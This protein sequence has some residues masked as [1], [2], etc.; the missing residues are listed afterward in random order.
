MKKKSFNFVKL[1]AELKLKAGKIGIASS[2]LE[3][4]DIIWRVICISTSSLRLSEFEPKFYSLAKFQMIL[5]CYVK[6]IREM[7]RNTYTD[8]PKALSTRL[9]TD[10]WKFLTKSA[11]ISV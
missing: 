9:L 2:N 4:S 11:I 5:R 1:I 8:G 7:V 10:N 6:R 3:F